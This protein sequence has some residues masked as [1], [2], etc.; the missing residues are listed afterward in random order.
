M[1]EATR[2]IISNRHPQYSEK[3]EDWRFF[4]QSY[5]GGRQYIS[6]NLR[7]YFKEGDKEFADRKSRAIRENHTKRVVELINTYLFKQDATRKTTNTLAQSF[8]DNFDGKKKSASVFMK[9]ASIWASV[10]GRVYIIIDRKEND[11]NGKTGTQADNINAKYYCYLI[12][13]EDVLDIAFDDETGAISWVLVRE[14]FRDAESPY[15]AKSYTEERYRLWERE[16]WTLFDK[17]GNSVEEGE[18]GLDVVPIVYL[19]NEE[20]DEYSGESMIAD[21]A[22]IDRAIFDNWSRLDS[23]VCDQ[24]FSQLI[25][26]IE[27][28]PADIVDNK[29]LR[30]QFLA[31]ATNRVILYSSQAQTEPKWISPDASQAAFILTMLQSMTKQLYASLGLQS[32]TGTEISVQSGVA[33]AYDFDKVNKLLG[34]K[35][36]ALQQCEKEIYK[37][38]AKWAGSES[39][40]VDV[41]Y[42]SEFDVKSLIDELDTAERLASLAISDTFTKEINKLVVMKALPKADDTLINT[43]FKE[44]D[45]KAVEEEQALKSSIF[46]FDKSRLSKT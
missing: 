38:F 24:T 26:P 22:Y 18:T 14:R 8:L 35:A 19:D 40:V 45:E 23:I 9:N 7:K 25:F 30:E 33:K 6:D 13:P 27:A 11:D 46:P 15:S 44:I 5:I 31:L 12:F 41:A 1:T 3:L 34:S 36:N 10:Y 4:K 32:D 29:D 2:S 20:L 43:I 17:A 39:I 37:I 21:V 28:L 42:P 16:K